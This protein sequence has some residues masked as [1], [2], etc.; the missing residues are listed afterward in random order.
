MPLNVFE[1]NYKEFTQTTSNKFY[2]IDNFIKNPAPS[3]VPL[4]EVMKKVGGLL[5]HLNFKANA[6][7]SM[8]D[9]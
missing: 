1:K 8:N 4:I 6:T 2:Q 5:T 3:N 7:P 9:I